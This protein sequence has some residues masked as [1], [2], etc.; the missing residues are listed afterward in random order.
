MKHLDH[1]GIQANIK[2]VV[3]DGVFEDVTVA[4]STVGLI[5]AVVFLVNKLEGKQKGIKAAVI[6]MLG[7]SDVADFASKIGIESS[8]TRKEQ[9]EMEE[10]IKKRMGIL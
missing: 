1:S 8:T 5:G 2:I 6:E 4:G 9:K 10:T 7:N 3:K